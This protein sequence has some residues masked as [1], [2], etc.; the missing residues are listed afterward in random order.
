VIILLWCVSE[1]VV[2]LFWSH[3]SL[4]TSRYECSHSFYLLCK[5]RQSVTL[6]NGHRYLINIYNIRRDFL[7]GSIY[8][9]YSILLEILEICFV[10]SELYLMW[11]F[12]FIW[13]WYQAAESR[14]RLLAVCP[15]FPQGLNFAIGSK[16]RLLYIWLIPLTWWVWLT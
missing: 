13:R 12:G 16:A 7:G 4:V 14:D 9:K 8:I 2:Q 3:L 11:V 10:F 15:Y 6:I 5:A 1:R